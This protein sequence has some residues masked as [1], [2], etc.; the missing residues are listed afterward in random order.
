[1]ETA[2]RPPSVSWRLALGTPLISMSAN[3]IV[4]SATASAFF[5]GVFATG[6][7]RAVAAATSTLT[8]P[9]RAQQIKRRSARVE[10]LGGDRRAVHDHDVVARHGPD[11]VG[12]V[13]GVL[14][15]AVL[16]VGAR[17]LR[18]G[19]GDLEFGDRDGVAE[20]GESLGE[21]VRRH[22]RVPDCQDPRRGVGL[23]HG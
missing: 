17:R 23:G 21:A 22:E 13:A 19:P 4:S 8:G 16:G 9:P 18:I 14:A 10:H 3:A 20:A 2:S 1:M 5:P 11:D 12:R 15:D 6:M 7:P